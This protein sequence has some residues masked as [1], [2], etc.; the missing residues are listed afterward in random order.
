[1][2]SKKSKLGTVLALALIAAILT[3]LYVFMHRGEETTDDAA[4]DGR[5]VTLS[6]KVSGY[7]KTLNISDNQ[8]VKSGDILLEVDPADYVNRRDRMKAALA[9]AEAAALASRS[10]V[11]TTNISAPS[12]LEAAQAQ[13]AAAAAN[14]DK[15]LSDL[16]RMHRLSNEARSQEQLE[17]AVANEKAARSNLEDARARLRAAATAP[18][19]IAAAEASSAQLEAEVK[20]AEAELAQAEKD[21]ADTKIIAP[22]DGRIIRRG[23]ER[24]DYVQPGQQLG[25]LVG[26]DLWVTADFKETQLTHIRPGQR[27][28]I[29]V[30]A[31]PDAK[32]EGKI[33]SVQ[34]GTGA[35]FSAFPPENATGNF[36]KIVQRVPVKIVFDPMPDGSLLLGPGMSVVPTVHTRSDATKDDSTKGNDP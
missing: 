24:G 10:N 34:S 11:E 15:A 9:A 2:K 1:M 27:V 23:V 18:K 35:F 19:T 13:V 4:I 21:L 26:N 17:Q 30:D 5:I 12:N 32:L 28:T 16:K 36:V 20:Q 6:P 29:T 31:F 7:I 14:W 3:G 8:L 25:S 22:M 33:D